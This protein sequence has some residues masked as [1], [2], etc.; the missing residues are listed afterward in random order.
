MIKTDLEKPQNQLWWFYY[1]FFFFILSHVYYYYYYYVYCYKDPPQI[2]VSPTTEIKDTTPGKDFEAQTEESDPQVKIE[3]LQ[4]WNKSFKKKQSSKRPK[5]ANYQRSQDIVQ[6]ATPP[7][8]NKI[9]ENPRSSHENEKQEIR[10]NDI[11]E[12]TKI[13]QIT[14]SRRKEL[15]TKIARI[16]AQLSRDLKTRLKKDLPTVPESK[17]I[18]LATTTKPSRGKS[19]ID[20]LDDATSKAVQQVNISTEATMSTVNKHLLNSN[21]KLFMADIPGGYSATPA[22]STTTVPCASISQET[23]LKKNKYQK[24]RPGNCCLQRAF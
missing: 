16:E 13:K 8:F 7:I 9:E 22:A 6:Q 3:Q 2:Y 18:T 4:T 10:N 20:S 15:N 19:T 1:I 23:Q 11:Y 17:T 12:S 14:K 5:K 21:A 24:K